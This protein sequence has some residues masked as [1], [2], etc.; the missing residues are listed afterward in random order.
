MIAKLE[1]LRKLGDDGA[2]RFWTPE[3]AMR[4]PDLYGP[5][6]LAVKQAAR[7]RQ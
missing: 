6:G 5:R 1:Y 2:Y 7:E 4:A 3:D